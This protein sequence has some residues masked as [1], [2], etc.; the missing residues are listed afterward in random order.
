LKL[1]FFSE[2]EVKLSSGLWARWLDSDHWSDEFCT[3]QNSETHKF[4]DETLQSSLIK[5]LVRASIRTIT[6][7]LLYACAKIEGLDWNTSIA[8]G[9]RSKRSLPPRAVI[10]LRWHPGLYI[11]VTWQKSSSLRKSALDTTAIWC[12]ILH[13]HALLPLPLSELV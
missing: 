11:K 1:G 2:D 5:D 6:R 4:A 13:H 12:L 8:I 9:S 10:Y 3:A 7:Q